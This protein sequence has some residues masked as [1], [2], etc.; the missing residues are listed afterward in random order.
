MRTSLIRPTKVRELA[1]GLG[2]QVSRGYV[3]YLEKRLETIIRG[4]AAAL[5]GRR[6]LNPVDAEIRWTFNSQPRTRI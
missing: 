3:G 4:D 6:R 2:K 1:R 5:G